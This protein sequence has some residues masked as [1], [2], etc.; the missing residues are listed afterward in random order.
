MR[1]PLV[2]RISHYRFSRWFFRF[3]RFIYHICTNSIC[4]S[5]PITIYALETLVFGHQFVGEIISTVV[6]AT[7]DRRFPSNISTEF[8][9][10]VK[11]LTI[12]L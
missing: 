6:I 5:D 3:F 1:T 8:T 7:E 9:V 4:D 2:E 11:T 12:H 10:C